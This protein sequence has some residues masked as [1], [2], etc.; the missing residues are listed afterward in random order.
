MNQKIKKFQTPAGTVPNPKKMNVESGNL[1]SADTGN[2][3]YDRGIFVK[4]ENSDDFLETSKEDLE[5]L[6]AEGKV[7]PRNPNQVKYGI[8]EL[9]RDNAV[10]K[11]DRLNFDR[12]A[13]SNKSGYNYNNNGELVD[14][15][16]TVVDNQYISKLS[17][18]ERRELG[19]QYKDI[20]MNEKTGAGRIIHS[21]FGNKRKALERGI[22]GTDEIYD[23]ASNR[24]AFKKP[25]YNKNSTTT[26]A[27]TTT[28]T[29]DTPGTDVSNTLTWGDVRADK[30]GY[31][32][33]K[34]TSG[35]GKGKDVILY[36]KK[37]EPDSEWRMTEGNGGE[38]DTFN[39]AKFGK[40]MEG[41]QA[42]LLDWYDR[43]NQGTGGKGTGSGGSGGAGG[44]KKI[45]TTPQS[46]AV[47]DYYNRRNNPSFTYQSNTGINMNPSGFGLNEDSMTVTHNGYENKTVLPKEE[48]REEETDI[49]GSGVASLAGI[50]GGAKMLG[51]IPNPLKGVQGR[52]VNAITSRIPGFG[53]KSKSKKSAQQQKD[54]DLDL[55][56]EH[57][58]DAPKRK[59][60][61]IYEKQGG[62]LYQKGG[63][64]KKA[65][66]EILTDT[67]I[68]NVLDSQKSQREW[69]M[70][71]TALTAMSFVPGLNV[72]SSG[73]S[74]GRD[75]YDEYKA[76]DLDAKDFGRAGLDFATNLIPG[77]KAARGVYK[78]AKQVMKPKTAAR[79]AG[80]SRLVFT[81]K[82]GGLIFSHEQG[83]LVQKK[84]LKHKLVFQE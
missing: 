46:E 3:V 18:R 40:G 47:K 77:A 59:A 45:K 10:T 63:A 68:G 80:L 79:V 25:N 19:K 32:Y 24:L 17:G 56:L 81:N 31:E 83:G 20:E 69:D 62:L 44:G 4:D 41:R 64:L 8:N 21:I 72:L 61:P 38:G 39:N 74:A 43:L 66:K 11:E 55:E 7:D 42:Y 33:K 30:G 34:M 50:Y 9:K 60:R 1:N 84:S 52:F 27:T 67:V 28:T 49:I 6:I 57:T 48:D 14:R 35:T 29:T 5:R 73:I 70:G 53:Y 54:E 16:G 65:G 26:P 51:K 15:M 75:L 12:F 71:D 78:V 76:G 37:G 82:Q 23:V 58:Y 22:K 36:R 2:L 13:T